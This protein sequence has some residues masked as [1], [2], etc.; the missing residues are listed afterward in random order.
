[1][2]IVANMIGGVS[3]PILGIQI[4]VDPLLPGPQQIKHASRGP[5]WKRR[6][7]RLAADPKNYSA[8]SIYKHNGVYYCHP[9]VLPL[10]K[11]AL[12]SAT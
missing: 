3:I 9:E 1:M 12:N 8:P 2:M 6:E 7:K 11:L 5:Y 4:F 10:L